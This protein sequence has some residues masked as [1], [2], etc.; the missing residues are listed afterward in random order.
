LR[1]GWNL[2]ESPLPPKAQYLATPKTSKGCG[3]LGWISRELNG[4]AEGN[5]SFKSAAFIAGVS[6]LRRKFGT[7]LKR[8]APLPDM[9]FRLNL[10]PGA[11]GQK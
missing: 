7:K 3:G 10:V 9:L 1:D 6:V 11:G 2:H 4:V 5:I 8:L